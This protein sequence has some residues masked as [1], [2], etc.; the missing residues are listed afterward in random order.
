MVPAEHSSA[1]GHQEVIGTNLELK[2]KIIAEHLDLVVCS[3]GGHVETS[4]G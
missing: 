4:R 3:S 2:H 1:D